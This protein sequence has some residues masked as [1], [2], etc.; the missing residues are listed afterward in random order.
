MSID[1]V[2]LLRDSAAQIY[3]RLNHIHP[4][5]DAGIEFDQWLDGAAPADRA[6]LLALRRDYRRLMQILDELA[7]LG[8]S[9]TQALALIR[10]QAS[11]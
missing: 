9:R 6:E 2:R 10:D 7:A 4:L 11:G 3:Q 5:D 1:S 8:A